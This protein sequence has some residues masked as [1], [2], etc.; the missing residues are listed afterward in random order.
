MSLV[1][2]VYISPMDFYPLLIGKDL[3]D[4]FEPLMDFKQLKIWAQVREPLPF[5]TANPAKVHCQVTE[6]S[7]F[8][9]TCGGAK[10]S[11][12]HWP[13][14]SC[15]N[16]TVEELYLGF[17]AQVQ[18]ILRNADAIQDE[19]DLKK[20]RQ[21]LYQYKASFAKDSLD[22]RLTN[23]HTVRIPSHPNAPP[24]FVKQ[25]KIPIASHEPVQEIIDSMLEKGII[26]PC[27]STYSAPI[28]PVLKPNGK[29][30]PTIDY[31]KLNQQASG[32]WTIPVHL[33]DQHKLAFTFSNRQ[34]TFNTLWLRV[35]PT[36]TLRRS[37]ISKLDFP[38]TASALVC[39]NDTIKT[40]EW[41][42]M[43]AKHCSHPNSSI[44]TVRKPCSALYGQSNYIGAQKVIIETCHQPVTFLNS[45]RIRDGVV[46]NA[47]IA[48]WLIALQ[49]RDIEAR[50]AQNQIQIAATHNIKELLI[51]TDS[52]YA[53]LSFTCHLPSWIRN[54][55]RTA[56]N[57]PVKHQH[58]FQACNAITREHDMLVYWKK[59]KGHSRQ[60]GRDKDFNDQTDALAKAPQPTTPSVV[61]VTRSRRLAAPTEPASQAV[62]LAPQI[63]KR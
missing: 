32:F 35:W 57:K 43:P 2:P 63:A 18:Q 8:G 61:A 25:Y 28:W 55:Y 26:R 40:K 62:S 14:S 49:G 47:R 54:G 19:T 29:W 16:A 45:Q 31:R 44:Q 20:L 10:L 51:C 6:G 39:I 22:C 41:S 58:L 50:Y 48:T 1:Q 60:P 59:V 17:E 12:T 13:I 3:L 15:H 23:L 42:L 27:N 30:R 4:R 5:P 24:T 46:T 52:N 7:L 33:E 56:N 9:L 38:T 11:T 53:R 36:L 21:I 37:S 34:Y